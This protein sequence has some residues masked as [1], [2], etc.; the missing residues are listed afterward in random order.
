MYL[1]DEHLYGPSG[2]CSRR[3]SVL[4]QL[5]DKGRV[6][7]IALDEAHLLFEWEHFR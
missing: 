2:E 6:G 5:A 7:L 1:T 3:L 4:Q